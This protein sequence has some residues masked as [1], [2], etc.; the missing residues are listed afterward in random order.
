MARGTQLIDLR[1]MLRAEAGHSTLVSAGIDNLP[2]LDQK[3][4]RTQAMLYD[5]YD[6]PFMQIKPF[7]DINEGQRY[8]DMPD[9][10]L[11]A[12]FYLKLWYNQQPRDIYRGIGPEQYRQYNPVLDQR[13]SPVRNWDIVSTGDIEST[14]AKL[15]QL[16]VWPL[17]NVDGMQ[18]QV[19]GKR[20]L[21]PLIAPADVCDI[22]DLAIVLVAAAD[23]LASQED[24][25][26]KRIQ[27]AANKR[28]MQVRGRTKS[29]STLMSMGTTR[30]PSMLG[31]PIIRVQ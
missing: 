20:A 21:R 10:N 4:R 2:S 18:I 28:I 12:I 8:Y 3:L 24:P 14:S 30:P 17:P 11:E 7:I 25:S 1:K 26:A 9:V 5:D 31:K 15:E 22:D 16:E 27:D 29:G 6:W 19:F 23:L 13:S